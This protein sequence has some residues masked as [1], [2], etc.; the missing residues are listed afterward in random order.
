MECGAKVI[1]LSRT[2]ADL[3]SLREEVRDLFLHGEKRSLYHILV[4][5]SYLTEMSVVTITGTY[6]YLLMHDYVYPGS[7]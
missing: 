6:M 3:D 4:T 5:F 1:A 2:Q 7:L